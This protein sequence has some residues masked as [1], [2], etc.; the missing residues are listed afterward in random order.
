MH[1]QLGINSRLLWLLLHRSLRI[2]RVSSSSLRRTSSL[3]RLLLALEAG[4]L[5]HWVSFLLLSQ[6]YWRD[7]LAW[8]SCSSLVLW[9]FPERILLSRRLI[10][11]R[12]HP[13]KRLLQPLR[14]NRQPFLY[15]L[16]KVH[17][18]R[19]RAHNHLRLLL[20]LLLRSGVLSLVLLPSLLR[21]LELLW[22][23][24]LVIPCQ[25]PLQLLNLLLH[26]LINCFFELKK[27]HF[28]DKGESACVCWRSKKS[29]N[30]LLKLSHLL[31]LSFK[32]SNRVFS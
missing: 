20:R 17:L 24:L 21:S 27:I 28:S 23:R 29:L 18:R 10:R 8:R 26:P 14:L 2:I 22:Y 11:L 13:L 6:S 30:C 1:L 19:A 32:V 5:M 15:F 12:Q 7:L 16:W 3:R 9:V 4:R 31:L 25:A